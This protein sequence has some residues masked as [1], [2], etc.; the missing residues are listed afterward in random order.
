MSSSIVWR[1]YVGFVADIDIKNLRDHE[2]LIGDIKSHV[3]HGRRTA[4]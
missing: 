4:N 1:I 2:M 3:S